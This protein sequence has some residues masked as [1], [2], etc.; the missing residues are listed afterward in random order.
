MIKEMEEQYPECT[1]ELLDNFD[2]AYRLWCQ[3]QHDYSDSN[4]RL[5][6]DL[7]SS[8]ERSQNNRLAQLG[9]IIRLNDKISRLINLYKKNIEETSAVSE[10][11]ED[12]S[13]D[14]MNY[15]NMLMVLRAGKW[16]K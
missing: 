12:T 9:I 11:I 2:K 7:S 14:I 1:N 16:G 5:G 4:I 3:K 10:S 15:A 6:L 8:S 13:V